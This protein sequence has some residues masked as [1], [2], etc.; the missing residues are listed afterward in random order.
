MH[1][2]SATLALVGCLLVTPAAHAAICSLDDSPKRCAEKVE[3]AARANTGEAVETAKAE[4]DT[5]ALRLASRNTGADPSLGTGASAITD[6]NPLLKLV[7]Q[8]GDLGGD[9]SDDGQGFTVD[10]NHFLGFLDQASYK[11]QLVARDAALYAPL[12]EALPEETRDARAGE[13]AESLSRFADTSFV[14]SYSPPFKLKT[15]S[16]G[17]DPDLY[18]TEFAQ[19]FDAVRRG[20]TATTSQEFRRLDD[21]ASQLLGALGEDE[22]FSQLGTAE[23]AE[24]ARRAYEAAQLARWR[25]QDE[26]DKA[27]AATDFFRFSDLVDNQPQL[28]ISVEQSE[29]SELV[30]PNALTVK[31]TYEIGWGNINGL[32]KKCGSGALEVGCF[33]DYLDGVKAGQLDA[34][35]RFSISAEYTDQ[36]RYSVELPA[37]DVQLELEDQQR[38]MASLAY[39]RYFGEGKKTRFDLNW[40]YEDV[41]NDPNRTNRHIGTATLSLPMADGTF[42]QLGVRYASEPEFRG[43]V[44]KELST[45]L[46]L[47]YKLTTPGNGSS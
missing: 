47:T 18:R 21:E 46:G 28:A 15:W 5:A 4:L 43:E 2:L 3:A 16:H 44:D 11:L 36:D 6:F 10:L 29:R 9:G 32:R 37:D 1:C 20:F 39:G 34:G 8:T 14:F 38:W 22:P 33:T 45:R 12:R 40:S 41:S 42:F 26:I 25:V 19:L 35:H 13:L 30:G 27:L 17:R 24:R 7:A 31:L 23:A